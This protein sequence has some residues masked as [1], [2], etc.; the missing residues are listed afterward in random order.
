MFSIVFH[1]QLYQI[2]LIGY[3]LSRSSFLLYSPYNNEHF[4]F[5]NS[6]TNWRKQFVPVERLNERE[7]NESILDGIINSIESGTKIV[8]SPL[9][10]PLF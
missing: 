2:S 4:S 5:S 6:V 8:E 7:E 9:N 3:R 10:F 1:V